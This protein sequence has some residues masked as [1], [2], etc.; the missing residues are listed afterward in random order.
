MT[1]SEPPAAA[2]QA[3]R[4]VSGAV[5]GDVRD[6]ALAAFAAMDR[7]AR[8]AALVSEAPVAGG[9]GL[10]F[11]AEDTTIEVDALREGADA[12][13]LRV[14]VL[15]DLGADV[16]LQVPGGPSIGL[17]RDGDA[18]VLRHL[19]EGPAALVLDGAG[20][21]LRTAWSLL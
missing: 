19:P 3:G 2:G 7:G 15:P 20:T 6:A 12:G 21:R 17:V 4:A 14:R 5:P 16:A 10:V 18:H 9:R 8:V 1:T 11:R 13:L